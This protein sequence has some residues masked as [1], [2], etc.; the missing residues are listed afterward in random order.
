MAFPGFDLETTREHSSC[1]Q[2]Y[3]HFCKTVFPKAHGVLC[4]MDPSSPTE[5]TTHAAQKGLF[6]ER[7]ERLSQRASLHEARSPR[8]RQ[9]GSDLVAEPPDRSCHHGW[10][11]RRQ[12]VLHV[13]RGAEEP[14]NRLERPDD[15]RLAVP[16]RSRTVLC[17]RVHE[18][19]HL[20]PDLLPESQRPVL[21]RG[22]IQNAPLAFAIGALLFLLYEFVFAG[23]FVVVGV[24]VV[25]V[26]GVVADFPTWQIT[27]IAR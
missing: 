8:R 18:V 15:D 21:V 3:R 4:I 7:P 9:A 17:D 11:G 13:D 23:V 12:H 26:V 10:L 20:V 2:I 27:P 6:H 25:G 14:G 5:R 1:P 22:T 16:D 19:S 24:F